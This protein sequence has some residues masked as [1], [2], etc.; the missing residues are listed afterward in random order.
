[1]KTLSIF[2]LIF[3]L[4]SM[5]SAGLVFT[6]NGEPQPDEITICVGDMIELDLEMPAGDNYLKYYLEYRL[7]NEQAEFIVD[8]IY[9]N[10]GMIFV[11]L[12][13]DDVGVCSWIEFGCDNFIASVPGPL[14][15]MNNLYVEC[16]EPTDVVMEVT[17]A[18]PT[19]I[20]GQEIPIGTLMHTLTIHQIPE[21]ATL[22]LLGLGGLFLRR[23]K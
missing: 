9:I 15:L 22:L 18:G 11:P 6:L 1:M 16:I 4:S 14:I 17:V 13:H 12:N 23:R 19:V 7:L 8:T 10:C 20:N 21:P 5:A 3:C 2:A